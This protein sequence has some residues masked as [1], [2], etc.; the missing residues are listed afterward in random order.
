MLEHIRIMTV[1][2]ET[3]ERRVLVM[4]IACMEGDWSVVT[5]SSIVESECICFCADVWVIMYPCALHET[6]SPWQSYHCLRLSSFSKGL[7]FSKTH[8][9]CFQPSPDLSPCCWGRSRIID[10]LTAAVGCRHLTV[11]QRMPLL[12]HHLC[13]SLPYLYASSISQLLLCPA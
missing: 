9:S 5:R 4:C 1:I 6:C 2:P 12:M 13:P 11:F 3:R 8:P 10:L 7:S